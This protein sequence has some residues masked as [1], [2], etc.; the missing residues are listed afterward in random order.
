MTNTQY[1]RTLNYYDLLLAS[2]GHI[3]GAGIYSIIGKLGATTKNY[4]YI[5]ILLAAIFVMWIAQSYININKKYESNDSE[6]LAIKEKF[7]DN[8]AS[9]LIYGLLIGNIL[10]CVVIAMSFGGYLSKL[11]GISVNLGTLACVL[12]STFVSIVGIRN[13]ADF[14]NLATLLETSGLLTIIVFGLYYIA[15]NNQLNKIN[16]ASITSHIKGLFDFKII[17]KI[18][19]GAYLILFAFFGFETL[20]KLSK[21]SIDPQKDIPLAMNHSLGISTIIY[22]LVSITTLGILTPQQLGK[23]IAP[24]SDVLAKLPQSYGYYASKYLGFAAISSTLNTYLMILVGTVR[25]FVDIVSSY[26]SDNKYIQKIY[27]ML[28]EINPKTKTPIN[29]TILFTVI[30]CIF[31]LTQA[32]FTTTIM[33]STL[34]LLIT[35]MAVKLADIL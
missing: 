27:S 7:G 15:S 30:I 18:I 33:F 25:M 6:Y 21:E 3:L 23:S 22:T 29:T 4:S 5:S 8:V 32:N 35:I 10:S 12:V 9:I 31:I 17:T 19:I 16:L 2:L 13:T 26:K 24:L 20:V 11:L 1:N 14:N 28:A 34:G